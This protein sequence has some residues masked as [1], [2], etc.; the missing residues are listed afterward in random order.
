MKYVSETVVN[1][2]H[3][4]RQTSRPVYRDV[5]GI[6]GFVIFKQ[7]YFRNFL[8]DDLILFIWRMNTD[9]VMS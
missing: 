8:L 7:W 1:S 3:L 9:A 6:Y 2:V 5:S 4:Q